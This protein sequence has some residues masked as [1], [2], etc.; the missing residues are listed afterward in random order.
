MIALPSRA[1][2]IGA[3]VTGAVLGA[4][5]AVAVTL[6]PARVAVANAK[7]DLARSE[8]RLA[9]MERDHA[10]A[11]AA[12]ADA[13]SV[14]LY[15]AQQRGDLLSAALLSAES[16]LQ[17]LQGERD[18]AIRKATTGRRCLDATALRVLDRARTAH[19][20]PAAHVPQPAGGA[21]AAGGAPAAP[22]EGDGDTWASD[23]G[24]ALW[25][26]HAGAQYETC[27]QRLA[28]LIQWHAGEPAP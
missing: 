15:H 17:T 12:A 10:R 13:A 21:A 4:L 6:P 19:S 18:D 2:L 16:Q 23:T 11:L 7:A 28:A 26:D 25:I 20:A 8:T 14:A 24:V 27:R 22:A 5:I 1:L 3:A 9:G